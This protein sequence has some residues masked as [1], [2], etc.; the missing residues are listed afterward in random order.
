[1]PE[2]VPD[3]LAQ[4]RIR[5]AWYVACRT[6]DLTRE[7]RGVTLFSVPIVLFRGADGA[8]AALLDRCPH[9]NVPLSQ[10][11]V[12]GG[13]LQCKY[14]GWRFHPDGRCVHIPAHTKSADTP[15]RRCT[16]IA[17][18]EQ[19]GFVWIWGDPDHPPSTEPPQLSAGERPGY[20]TVRRSLAVQGSIH[21]VAE[22][23]LDV[24]HTAFLHR[25]LFR[26]DKER[27]P[28]ECRIERWHDRVECHFIG[29]PRP[30]G[31]AGRLL[32]PSGGTVSHVDRFRLPSIVEVEYQIGSENHIIL[33]GAITP[34][35]DH[36]VT[37]HA[38]VS[39]RT[40]F[41]SWL[42]R[43][44]VQPIALRIFAQD[45][46]ILRLQTENMHRFNEARFIST[47]L[48]VLGPHILRLMR[49]A[50]RGDLDPPQ[51]QPYTRT[52][53]MLL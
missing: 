42:L 24:P 35:S 15:A 29:E 49:Q 21:A 16:T 11:T 27:Q 34:H 5:A 9:R 2:S 44:F 36:D 43:P 25:G 17:V 3:S 46:H 23:A 7:P 19:Q 22:N 37:L 1:M 33:N 32:S 13:H 39:V 4:P 20:L 6:E 18:R 52:V 38:V 8:A 41:P 53:T 30:E 14:H 10:G 31:L 51:Q 28:I 45:Q 50:A 48:D 12:V 47:E 26:V 40:R